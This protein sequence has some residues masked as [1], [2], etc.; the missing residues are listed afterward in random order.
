MS[1]D[2][3]IQNTAGPEGLQ[4]VALLSRSHFSLVYRCSIEGYQDTLDADTGDQM[5]LETDIRGTVDFVFGYARAAF[6]GCRLLVRSSGASKP[7]AH[8]VVTAQGRNNPLDRSGFAF[9]NCSVTADEGANLTGV[10]TFLGR[11]WK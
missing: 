11:P 9:Q 10:E 7:G 1:Q 5:Y 4:A 3:T 2:L 6:L 8:N